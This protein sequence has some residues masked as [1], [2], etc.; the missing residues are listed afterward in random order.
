MLSS[1]IV[2]KVHNAVC[3]IGLLP[4]PLSEWIR[5]STAQP[6]E[7]L[8][9]G[10]L[11]RPNTVMTNEHVLKG[12]RVEAEKW[13]LPETQLF[14]Y[15]LAPSRLP[16]PP[17][18]YRMIRRPFS[19]APGTLDIALLEIKPEP[20]SHF[21]HIDP[22]SVTQSPIVTVAEEVFV[23]GYPYGNMLLQPK[24]APTRDGPVLQQGFISGISPFAGANKPDELLLDVRTADKMSGSPVVRSATGEVIGIH[25]AGAEVTRGISTTSFAIPL[26]SSQV[27][28]WLASHDDILRAA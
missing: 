17:A 7:V 9:T 28:V 13:D 14:L 1:D 25:H 5:D 20:S 26:V 24:G 18:T 15:F 22:L 10:F 8:G 3:A 6:L 12:I 11:V 19:P 4:I 27:S 21:A 16:A 23:C 2:R